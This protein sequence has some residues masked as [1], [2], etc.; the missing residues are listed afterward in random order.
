[1]RK[2]LRMRRKFALILCGLSLAIYIFV[3]FLLNHSISSEKPVS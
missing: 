3:Y 1:M 2:M